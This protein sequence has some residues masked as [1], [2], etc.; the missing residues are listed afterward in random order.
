[1]IRLVPDDRPDVLTIG[2]LL[3]IASR[4]RPTILGAWMTRLTL[5]RLGHPAAG[6]RTADVD[7]G[8]GN[9]SMTASTELRDVLSDLGYV[10]DAT[11]RFRMSRRTADGVRIVD[12]LAD[13][14]SGD[15]RAFPVRHL[16]ALTK[17]TIALVVEAHGTKAELLVPGLIETACLRALALETGPQSLKFQDYV[18][19]ML[20]MLELVEEH[21]A[22]RARVSRIPREIRDDVGSL[23]RPLF[24]DPTSPGSLAAG[25]G[26]ADP[27]LEARQ[28]Q[29]LVA[30]FLS[31][32]P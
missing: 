15:P 2:A 22:E 27:A 3:D 17:E 5:M 9:A 19:D 25:R 12:L 32:L 16:D 14:A 20:A 30:R 4:M 11:Y 31:R 1:M 24:A 21:A 10:E 13:A 28:A 8:V 29:A 7:V 26:R 23:L 6:R 18:R